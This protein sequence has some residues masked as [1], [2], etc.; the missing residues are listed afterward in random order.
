M[1]APLRDLGRLHDLIGLPQLRKR[2]ICKIFS[3]G[4]QPFLI[5]VT[6]QAR[7]EPVFDKPRK[8]LKG[9]R[10]RTGQH[11]SRLLVYIPMV[12]PDLDAAAH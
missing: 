4:A 9:T 12:T 5:V 11:R 6:R 10:V 7:S 2:R 3:R 8:G 1:H